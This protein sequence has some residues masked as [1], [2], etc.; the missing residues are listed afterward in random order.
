M[1]QVV[2][3]D[4]FCGFGVLC[5]A[6]PRVGFLCVRSAPAHPEAALGSILGAQGSETACSRTRPRRRSTPISHT[7]IPCMRAMATCHGFFTPCQKTWAGVRTSAQKGMW[8]IQSLWRPPLQVKPLHPLFARGHSLCIFVLVA[9]WGD[10][11][12]DFVSWPP[13]QRGYLWT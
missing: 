2:P 8:A 3:P 9:F 1:R 12:T 11:G 5:Y 6:L 13:T 10:V 7:L 4:L